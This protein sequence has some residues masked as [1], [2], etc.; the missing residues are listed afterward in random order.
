MPI[1]FSCP[2]GRQLQ[3][4]DEHAGKRARCPECAAVVAVPVADAPP[5]LPPQVGGQRPPTPPPNR[6]RLAEPEETDDGVGATAGS[7][8][9]LDHRGRGSKRSRDPEEDDD[10]PR[11]RRRRFADAD[12]DDDDR[13]RRRRRRDDEEDEFRVRR[14]S[15]PQRK[16]WNNRV[17]GGLTCMAIGAVWFCGGLAFD[18]LFYFPPVLF[19]IGL[20]SLITGLVT[21]RDE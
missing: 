1:T 19:V 14:R 20:I 2:C 6:A 17:T 16:L 13:P 11:R 18:V 8:D 4:G 21:G 3:V 9:P 7:L 12:D 15:E 10:R 5:P